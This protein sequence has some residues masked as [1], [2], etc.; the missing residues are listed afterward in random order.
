MPTQLVI[1]LCHLSQDNNTPQKALGAV[2]H[3]LEEAGV[4]IAPSAIAPAHDLRLHI[5]VLPRLE[6]SPLM[7]LP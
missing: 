3:A 2:R 5:A 4:E 1:F 6:S 7:V